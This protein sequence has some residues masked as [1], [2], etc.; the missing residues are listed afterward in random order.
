MDSLSG[1]HAEFQGFLWQREVNKW[2]VRG[3]LF[4]KPKKITSKEKCTQAEPWVFFSFEGRTFLQK[5]R[6]CSFADIGRDCGQ[7]Y[8]LLQMLSLSKSQLVSARAIRV[9]WLEQY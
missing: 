1:G 8:K 2:A 4:F 6:F 9:K 3:L 7:V 5:N